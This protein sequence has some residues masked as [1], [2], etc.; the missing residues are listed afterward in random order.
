LGKPFQ[1]EELQARIEALLRRQHAGSNSITV[2]DYELNL[3]TKQL[4]VRD[5]TYDLTRT[6]FRLAYVVFI[7]PK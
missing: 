6:E 3:E 4:T 7:Q 5:E 2:A 1:Y